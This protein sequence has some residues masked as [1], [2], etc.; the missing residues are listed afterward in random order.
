M[1]RTECICRAAAGL[2]QWALVTILSPVRHAA[3]G[4]ASQGQSTLPDRSRLALSHDL[5]FCVFA[6]PAGGEHHGFY[7]HLALH[8]VFVPLLIA[9]ANGAHFLVIGCRIRRVHRATF[10]TAIVEAGMIRMIQQGLKIMHDVP[11][12][13]CD[14]QSPAVPGRS[15][16][17]T[18]T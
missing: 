18:P 10:Q 13:C 16:G 1:I 8:P 17:G 6:V 12:S 5:V 15:C 3:V 4:A 7:D 11:S 14:Y 2:Y 9:T